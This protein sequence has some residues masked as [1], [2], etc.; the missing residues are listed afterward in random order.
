MTFLRRLF[1]L[2][3]THGRSTAGTHKASPRGEGVS[4]SHIFPAPNIDRLFAEADARK[5]AQ[6]SN[7][8]LG[9]HIFGDC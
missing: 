8:D 6:Y 1:T 3:T 9:R 7:D 4:S 2:L 5:R